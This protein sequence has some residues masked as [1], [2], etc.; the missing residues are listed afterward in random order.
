MLTTMAKKKQ[1]GGS[2]GDRHQSTKALRL[3]DDVHE[4]LAKM[5]EENDRP[6]VREARRIIIR[7]LKE[8]GFWPPEA[9]DKGDE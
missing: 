8:A 3:G 1:S 5:A 9:T 4:A 6:I 2:S 7:A